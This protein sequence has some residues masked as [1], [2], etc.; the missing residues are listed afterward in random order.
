[1]ETEAR[2]CKDAIGAMALSVEFVSILAVAE[3]TDTNER[4]ARTLLYHVKHARGLPRHPEPRGVSYPC[5]IR[6]PN[7]SKGM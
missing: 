4:E 5:Q 1:M 6:R 2:D 3:T 7:Q